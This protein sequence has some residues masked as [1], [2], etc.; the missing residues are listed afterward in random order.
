[1]WHFHYASWLCI[2]I[3]NMDETVKLLVTTCTGPAFIAVLAAIWAYYTKVW[4]PARQKE[5]EVSAVFNNEQ[6]RSIQLVDAANENSALQQVLANEKLLIL[7]LIESGNGK[8]HELTKA[9]LEGNIEQA[10]REKD[11]IAA[12]NETLIQGIRREI[13]L[14]PLEGI[15]NYSDLKEVRAAS[16]ASAAVQKTTE[17]V[18]ASTASAP[19]IS[20]APSATNVTAESTRK[21]ND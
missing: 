3:T 7:H 21:E 18:E 14:P 20:D 19:N 5:R 9:V 4:E 15:T 2:L 13:G 8:L 16:V 10:L 12:L 1:M 11:I 17:L 6:K